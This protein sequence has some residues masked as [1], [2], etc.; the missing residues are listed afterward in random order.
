MPVA[1]QWL[2]PPV[3]QCC[4]S[5]ALV[6]DRKAFN[7]IW[8][9]AEIPLRIHLR[10]IGNSWACTLSAVLLVFFLFILIKR[11]SLR[12]KDWVQGRS[13]RKT[14]RKCH[15][16]SCF[17][18]L[19]LSYTA[20]LA[21]GCGRVNLCWKHWTVLFVLIIYTCIW[22]KINYLVTSPAYTP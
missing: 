11:V 4:R 19:K 3:H 14:N 17:H 15:K 1:R 16:T 5:K 20:V 21:Y 7:S 10:W 18:S 6:H 8:C 9:T 13:H 2:E 22:P 12:T